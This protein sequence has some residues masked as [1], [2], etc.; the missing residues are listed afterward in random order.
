[1]III[2][3]ERQTIKN[4]DSEE[5]FLKTTYRNFIFIFPCASSFVFIVLLKYFLSALSGYLYI[6]LNL[7]VIFV[8]LNFVPKLK[9]LNVSYQC[10]GIS[11]LADES[12]FPFCNDV[13]G[14]IN[15]LKIK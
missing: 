9:T 1:M 4:N 15:S 3:V 2:K 7:L 8:C 13:Y 5:R 11:R 10:R 12:D 6:S 14:V